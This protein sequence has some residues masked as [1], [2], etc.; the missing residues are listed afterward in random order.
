[1]VAT[2]R[3]VPVNA[4]AEQGE[5]EIWDVVHVTDDNLL[6]PHLYGDGAAACN[7]DL[8]VVIKGDVLVVDAMLVDEGLVEGPEVMG[9]ATVKDGHLARG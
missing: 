7:A 8:A 5:A 1:M 3:D 2:A 9:G 6:A 4:E